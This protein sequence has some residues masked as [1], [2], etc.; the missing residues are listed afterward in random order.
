M[1]KVLTGAEVNEVMGECRANGEVSEYRDGPEYFWQMPSLLGSGYGRQIQLRPGLWLT[2][3]DYQKRQAHVYQGPHQPTMPLTLA[4]YL[5]GGMRVDNS[6]LTTTQEEV[7]GKSY[8]YCLPDTFEV[9]EY[10]AAQHHCEIRIRILPELMPTLSDRVNEL[11][12]HLR[13][14]IEHPE[15]ASLYYP[16]A[17][18]PAQQH[19]LQQ[20]LQWPYQ[21]ITRQ[22]YL[23]GKVLELL[24]LQFE[25]MLAPR[26]S[27]ALIT[28]DIDRIY[29]A[30]DILIQ[31]MAHPPSLAELAKRVQLNERKLKEGFHQVFDTTVF[32]YLHN[33]RMEQARYLLQT[34]QLNIQETARWVGYASRSSFVVAF[35]KKFQAVPSQYLKGA[36]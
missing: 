36:G 4:F 21:G 16:T 13:Q 27:K 34:G 6:G 33:H 26:A 1:A 25:Q 32:G 14:A 35:K 8:L 12:I 3:G 11:P 9:E 10:P 22:L 20:I 24:A 19:V 2:V 31:N 17:I 30:R 23:E 29:Q 7:A 15:Q 5:S 28:R 18:T